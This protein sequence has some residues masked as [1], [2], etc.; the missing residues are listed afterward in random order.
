MI[1]SIAFDSL[2]AR[3]PI[4]GATALWLL[5]GFSGAVSATSLQDMFKTGETFT[6]DGLV[7][8]NFAPV[9]ANAFPAGQ[10]LEN[11]LKKDPLALFNVQALDFAAGKFSHGWGNARAADA[12]SI[13]FVILADNG[14]TAGVDPGF[15]LDGATEWTVDAGRTV[16]KPKIA[17]GQLSAFAYDVK[18]TP[19]SKRISSADISQI[20]AIDAVGPDIFSLSPFALPDVAAGFVLQF[21]MDPNSDD[22]LNAILNVT[23][24]LGVQ[25]PTG[26]MRFSQFNSW[27]GFSDRDAIRVVNV[28]GLRASSG[29][30]FTMNTLEQRIDPPPPQLPQPGTLLLISIGLVGL[31]CRRRRSSAT[32]ESP[33]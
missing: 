33:S 10:D 27:S 9:L 21:I 14:A 32:S 25:S 15:R 30:G 16:N 28:I 7:F 19:N 4:I 12:A 6:Q 29:G 13:D 11:L 20:S 23:L 26:V 2:R 24:D 18:K 3:R 31:A 8:S 22:V 17:S 1:N 5:L